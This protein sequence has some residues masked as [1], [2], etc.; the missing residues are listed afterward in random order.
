[1]ETLEFLRIFERFAILCHFGR[2]GNFGTFVIFEN[3]GSLDFFYIFLENVK[4]FGISFQDFS[5]LYNCL[6]LFGNLYTLMQH[7]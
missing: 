5:N 7:S 2:L 6:Q 3:F 4:N 1:M